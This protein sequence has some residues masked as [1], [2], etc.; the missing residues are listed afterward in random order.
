ENDG[1][2]FI[3]GTYK[4]DLDKDAKK[5]MKVYGG[6][7]NNGVYFTYFDERGKQKGIK[8]FEFA[9]F[10]GFADFIPDQT[11][12]KMNKK[13]S[14]GKDVSIAYDVLVHKPVYEKDRMI[15]VSEA[16]YAEYHYEYS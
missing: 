14:Q 7:D 16:Y 13:K 8:F 11:E 9:Q 1:Q 3:I 6:G 4:N 12:N 2:K 5:K 10:D 15:V